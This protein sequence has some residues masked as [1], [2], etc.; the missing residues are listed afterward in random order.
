MNE[1]HSTI[2]QALLKSKMIREEQ[3]KNPDLCI[4]CHYV[5]YAQKYLKRLNRSDNY[6][7]KTDDISIS[8]IILGL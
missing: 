4:N 1:F 3:I 2:C 6:E 8:T 5:E 7:T